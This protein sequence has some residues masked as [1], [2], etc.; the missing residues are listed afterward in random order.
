MSLLRYLVV[1]ETVAVQSQFFPAVENISQAATFAI[2]RVIDG[3]LDPSHEHGIP[4]FVTLSHRVS[5]MR[6]GLTKPCLEEQL[7]GLIQT[8]DDFS[9]PFCQL[10]IRQ[11]L[12]LGKKPMYGNKDDA[13]TY[14]VAAI[15]EG[16]KI[17]VAEKNTTWPILLSVIDDEIAGQVSHS[18]LCTFYLQ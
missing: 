16:A 2:K 5:L 10:R 12:E 13:Q 9:L 3:L 8:V 17:A 4:I 6:L 14:V 15:F 11:L 7:K 1:H 18:T